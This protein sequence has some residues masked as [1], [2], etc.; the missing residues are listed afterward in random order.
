VNLRDGG[1]ERAAIFLK[2]HPRLR[3]VNHVTLALGNREFRR[4]FGRQVERADLAIPRGVQRQVER[5]S[6]V[7][8]ANLKQIRAVFAVRREGGQDG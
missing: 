8:R 5:G 1:R 4:L 3:L 7:E 6:P 2:A